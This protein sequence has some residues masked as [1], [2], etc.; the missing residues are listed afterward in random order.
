MKNELKSTATT[1]TIASVTSH[2]RIDGV[3]PGVRGQRAFPTSRRAILDPF[4]MLDHIGPEQLGEG[5][6]VDGVM[7]P[8]RGF[9]TLTIMLEGVMHHVDSTGF[10][11]DLP[12]GSTQNMR[13][14]R[15]IQHG[16]DMAA[17]PATGV[18]HEVQLWVTT[19]TIRKMDPP[20]IHT[21]QPGQKPI[22]DRGTYQVEVITG[23][24][25]GHT[26]P[27]DTTQPTRVLHVVA[28]DG[29]PIE[30]E[31]IPVDWN[32]LVYVLRGAIETDQ[33]QAVQFETV[34]YNN[35][36]DRIAVMARAGTEL[37]V[38]TGKPTN[39][40]IAMGGPWVMNTKA[41]LQQA[42]ADYA[43]GLI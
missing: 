42:Q 12:T 13:A 30:V 27:L 24:F 40:P 2:D 9:E 21:A 7:H 16:G 14:G 43:A 8:H 6:Y 25:D 31:G 37:L 15:G 5:F 33:V 23:T 4:V 19:P 26:S 3:V 11:E 41:E 18:F 17:D 10:R 39:E 29:G 34:V 28:G 35:D 22:I 1:R 20:A 36:G 32:S 38:L